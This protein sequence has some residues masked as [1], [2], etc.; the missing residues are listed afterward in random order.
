MERIADALCNENM[1]GLAKSTQ[2]TVRHT[3]QK[4][5]NKGAG[6]QF[7]NERRSPVYSMTHPLPSPK[8]ESLLVEDAAS[9]VAYIVRIGG[10]NGATVTAT[11]DATKETRTVECSRHTA[12]KMSDAGCLYES[13]S[14]IGKAEW[15]TEPWSLVNF[16]ANTFK[17]HYRGK[18]SKLFGSLDKEFIDSF[19]S[20]DVDKYM[21][22]VRGED[23]E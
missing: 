20:M 4:I 11:F 12:K 16:W 10:K 1:D 5:I 6:V 13:V 23:V 7:L 15:R 8:K 2:R 22:E 3:F 18:A 14:L 17:K 19:K 21:A 9:L